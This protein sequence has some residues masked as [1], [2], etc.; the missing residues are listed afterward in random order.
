MDGR[1]PQPG[2]RIVDSNIQRRVFPAFFFWTKEKR[3]PGK[4]L[5][6]FAAEGP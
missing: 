5:E 4:A 2:D 3:L 6:W 1:Y